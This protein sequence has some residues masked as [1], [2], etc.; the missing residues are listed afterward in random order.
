MD[1]PVGAYYGM[2]KFLAIMLGKMCQLSL[3][4]WMNEWMN[5]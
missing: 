4:E 5:G 2:V 3:L 1:D